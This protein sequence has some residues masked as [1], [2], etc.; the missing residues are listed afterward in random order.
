MDTMHPS[1]EPWIG[2]Y[3]WFML[4]PQMASFAFLRPTGFFEPRA[5][6]VLPH[7]FGF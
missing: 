1:T 3:G 4:G 2:D 5:A 6:T 7:V